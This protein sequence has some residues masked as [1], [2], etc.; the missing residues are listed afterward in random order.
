MISDLI[1]SLFN[2]YWSV[3]PFFVVIA[4]LL[5]FFGYILKR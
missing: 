4:I 3:V 2:D 1:I 5:L